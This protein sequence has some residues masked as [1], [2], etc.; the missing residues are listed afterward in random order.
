M[1]IIYIY[2]FLPAAFWLIAPALCLPKRSALCLPAPTGC[3]PEWRPAL[4]ALR[5]RPA[6]EWKR[7]NMAQ[8]DTQT[9]THTHSHIYVSVYLNPGGSRLAPQTPKRHLLA[10][11]HERRQSLVLWPGHRRLK[12]EAQIQR[13][14]F[15]RVLFSSIPSD[16]GGCPRPFHLFK[17]LRMAISLS[18][19]YY[20]S[21][22]KFSVTARGTL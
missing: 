5:G 1:Y 21:G 14:E 8:T 9:H 6:G 4:W 12:E 18:R 13:P 16:N 22:L 11:R 10:H 3:R 7:R 20:P 17:C 19:N 2:I 15:P